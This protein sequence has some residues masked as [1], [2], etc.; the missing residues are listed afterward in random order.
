MSPH[1]KGLPDLDN[2]GR[3]AVLAYLAGYGPATRANLHYWLVA[4]LSAGRRRLEGWLLQLM[5]DANVVEVPVDGHPMIHLREH[6]ESLAV[7]EPRFAEVTLLPGHDQW[8][9]GPG[10]DDYR[11]VP[12]A[13]RSSV[14]RGANLVLQSGVVAGTWKVHQGTLA[15][16]WCAGAGVPPQAMIEHECER[17]A[18]LLERDLDVTVTVA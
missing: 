15:V 17:L 2:A 11:V 7:T 10:I 16:D 8:V 5:D 3:R 14:T 6:L 18:G 9:L 4:G 12:T 13:R 1:W